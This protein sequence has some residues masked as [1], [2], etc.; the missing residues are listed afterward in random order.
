MEWL[1]EQLTR[2]DGKGYKA[3]KAL[4]GKYRFPGFTLSVD[5]VQ[6]DPY[7]DA[8]RIRIQVPAENAG[9]AAVDYA[10]PIRQIALED[11]L[12]RAVALAIERHV[13]GNR[14]MGKSGTF[15]IATSGQQILQRNAVVIS[16]TGIEARMRIALPSYGRSIAAQEA[17][18]MFFDE[19]PHVVNDGLCIDQLDATDLAAHLD[20]AEDQAWLR[21]W[22]GEA[23][24]V[25]FVADGSLLPRRSGV[26]D[27]PLDAG[28][29]AFR[30]PDSLACEPVLPHAG[31]VRGLGIPQGVTLIVGG[32]FH[33]KSTLLRALERGVYD[34]IPGDGR[35]R[36]ATNASAVKIR[37]EDGR[38]VSGVDISPFIDNLP[39]GVDTHRFTSDN[40]S[41]STSQATNIV[42][43]LAGGCRVLLVDEDTSAANFMLRDARMQALVSKDKEPIT[44]F[45]HRV[46][47]LYEQHGVSTVL[48]MG[49]TGDYFSE[50]DTVLMMDSYEP[51]DVT[52]QAKRLATPLAGPDVAVSCEPLTIG[53]MR[54]PVTRTI[55]AIGEHG[56]VKIQVRDAKGLRYGCEEVDLSAVEQLIDTGQTLAIGYLI[57]YY[58]A[59]RNEACDLVEGVRSALEEVEA[60]GLDILPPYLVGELAMPRLHEVLAAINRLRSLQTQEK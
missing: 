50:A 8:S 27:R 29:V 58:A 21:D 14:G 36:V 46:R 45:T 52:A 5:H 16:E 19:L 4:E 12:N 44:P 6:G 11:F 3:Y 26:D 7:A 28:A 38:A 33:G 13:K 47:E 31:R 24:L 25:A 43:A 60:R 57:R 49:G 17:R 41:G 20:C 56:R 22:L 35:E 2:L 55:R 37:A 48:V 54:I 23:G 53:S 32:G 42:E 59:Q 9:L 30:A 40:A 15:F 1:R 51:A 18:A 34:H 10:A 39:F